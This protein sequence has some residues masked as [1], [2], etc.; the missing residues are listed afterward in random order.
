MLASFCQLDTSWGYLGRGT[1]IEKKYFHHICLAFSGL[2]IVAGGTRGSWLGVMSPWGQVTLNC[3]QKLSK[4]WRASQEAAPT[5]VSVPEFGFLV[6][7]SSLG[8]L[9]DEL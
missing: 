8:S 1:S 9:H 4:L 7:A 5:M 6:C 3:V 2:M